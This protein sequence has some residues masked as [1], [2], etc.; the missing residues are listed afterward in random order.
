M[1]LHFCQISGFVPQSSVRRA[2]C[3]SFSTT[4]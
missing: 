4:E 2:A 1:V 3:V